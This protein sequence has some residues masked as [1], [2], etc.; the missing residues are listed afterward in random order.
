MVL[1]GAM[2][3]SMMTLIITVPNLMTSSS[4]HNAEFGDTQHNNS[5]FSNTQNNNTHLG[6]IQQND[7]L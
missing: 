5:Q 4:Q 2:T 3:L 6:D 7:A 1:W